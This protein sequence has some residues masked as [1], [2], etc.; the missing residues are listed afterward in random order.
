MKSILYLLSYRKYG[1]ILSLFSDCFLSSK[2]AARLTLVLHVFSKLLVVFIIFF[3]S[4]IILK[5]Q[6]K[7]TRSFGCTDVPTIYRNLRECKR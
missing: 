3:T 1:Q 5:Q 7:T 6:A 4:F 2:L